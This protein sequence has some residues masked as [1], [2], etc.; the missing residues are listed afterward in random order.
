MKLKINKFKAEDMKVWDNF[1]MNNS[2]NG[3]IYHTIK[4]LSYHKDRFEDSSIMI[5]DKNKLI[6]VF[7]CCKVGQEYYSHR[8]ST[9]GGIVILE[10]YYELIKLTEIMDLIYNYYN[11]NL[12]IKLSETVYF[13]NNI[14]NDLLNFV[15][16]QKCK[17]YQDISLFFNIN[18]NDNVI[19][20]FEKNDNKRLLLKYIND[21]DKEIYFIKT[22]NVDDYKKYYELLNKNS[23]E[24]NDAS[25]LHTLEEFIL[26][27]EL[28]GEKQ[29]LFLSKDSNGDILSGALVF[30][31]N[32]DTYYTVYL[33]T[34][35]EK[36]NSQVFYLLYEL[37]Q[38][39]KRNN[40]SIV[41]LGAC[42][43]EGG[44]DILY[45]KYKFK[46]SCGCEPCLKY[47]Y[48][49]KMEIKINSSNLYL[50]NME[51][52]EQYLISYFWKNNKYANDM[53]F[54]KTNSFNYD[55]QIEWYNKTDND[56]SSIYLSI[57][58]N[59]NSNFI[60]YCGIKN[61]TCDECELFIVLLDSE[62]YKKGFGKEGFKNLINYTINKFP[63]KEIYLN[64]KNNN[65]VAINIYK[66]LKFR[67]K[68][69]N[70]NLIK[71]ILHKEF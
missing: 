67:I 53:F 22:N 40:I 66:D 7:P 6:A 57:F 42:S 16:S 17:N 23:Y 52:S 49:Y 60:G 20:S 8:G 63:N 36:K 69:E 10:K 45:S 61:I 50:K 37:F 27:K 4:F 21:Q 2:L 46:S 59:K 54:L 12:H 71:M 56:N 14:K 33:M 25:I 3:T 11:G 41:N 64:V 29:F 47:S 62:F 65:Q 1:V 38:L 34:N 31:I 13:R 24:K 39:A 28:L 43:T 26:L 68:S 51:I 15:L 19:D 18:K 9:C 35:Y 70:K 30:L 44:K 48:K 32:N 55:N 5:Y 58:E